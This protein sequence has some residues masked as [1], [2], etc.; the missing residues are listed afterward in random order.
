MEQILT[1]YVQPAAQWFISLLTPAEW[2]AVFLLMLSTMFFTHIA[3]VVW[4]W[5]PIPGDRRHGLINLTAC[6]FGLGLGKALWPVTGHAPWWIAGPVMGGGGAIVAWKLAWPVFST[7][8]PT[9]AGKVN[10]D[11]RKTEGMPPV[12]MSERRK[13]Q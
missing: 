9:I 3:K 10:L 8:F 4:R 11:R 13:S 2:S 12:G 7:F 5:M 1:Q 6:F